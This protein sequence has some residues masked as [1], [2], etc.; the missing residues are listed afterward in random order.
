[1]AAGMDI[2]VENIDKLERRLN[3]L[4]RQMLSPEDLTPSYLIDAKIGLEEL[5]EKVFEELELL[6]PYGVE[7]PVPLFLSED[8]RLSSPVKVVGRGCF[9]T[10]LSSGKGKVSFEA[11][12]FG[13]ARYEEEMLISGEVDVVFTPRI[14][15][16]KGE[17]IYQL[18]I[19]DW[20]SSNA[21]A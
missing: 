20:R 16:W 8:L 4:A 13:L 10:S 18:E 5:N 21:T 1:M 11:I 17:K 6:P 12:G 3:E 2:R 19:K 9:R 7:N 15:R 14:N